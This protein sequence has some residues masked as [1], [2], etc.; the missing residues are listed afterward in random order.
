MLCQFMDENGKVDSIMCG[1]SG[2]YCSSDEWCTHPLHV[3]Q[4]YW[5]N[6]TYPKDS[7][8]HS[9]GKMIFHNCLLLRF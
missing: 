7:S 6:K 3:K 8:C 4:S 9:E 5:I 2:N 1:K